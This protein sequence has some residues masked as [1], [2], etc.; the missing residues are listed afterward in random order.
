MFVLL[1]FLALVTAN[2][3]HHPVLNEPVHT[4]RLSDV[5]PR[6]MST[7]V[8]QKHKGGNK[9]GAGDQWWLTDVPWFL[10]PP[11]E[12]GPLPP[13]MYTSYYHRPR[14]A[15]LTTPNYGPLYSR[16]DEY[17]ARPITTVP[18]NPQLQL[19]QN[20]AMWLT[21]N[22]ARQAAE[23]QHWNDYRHALA[24]GRN[25]FTGDL[26]SLIGSGRSYYR[27][28]DPTMDYYSTAITRF[29]PPVATTVGGGGVI[30]TGM[31][32]FGGVLLESSA[33]SMH[34]PS[35]RFLRGRAVLQAPIMLQ[36]RHELFSSAYTWPKPRMM[37]ATI[38]LDQQS[39]AVPARPPLFPTFEQHFLSDTTVS[40]RVTD[41][42]T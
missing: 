7:R 3:L 13:S 26:R 40:Y 31:G 4:A 22:T 42:S 10:P 29:A 25:Y 37:P 1:L 24:L 32:G 11:P 5:S 14:S 38:L 2:R 15:P 23:S 39:D 41:P 33:S 34:H 20:R 21:S 16:A 18:G 6:L 35:H 28:F 8:D 27:L 17:S 36:S 12:W 9:A 30:P 19:I